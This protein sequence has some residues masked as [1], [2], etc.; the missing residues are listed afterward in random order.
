MEENYKIEDESGDKNYFTIVPNYILNHSTAKAQALYLQLKR[1]GGEKGIANPGSRYL[2]NKLKI[3]YNTLKKELKYLLD[4]GWIEYR[5]DVEIKTDGGLQKVKSYA[6]VDLWHMNNDYYR[7]AV[8]KEGAIKPETARTIKPVAGGYQN[9]NEIRTIER[10]KNIEETSSSESDSWILEEKLQDMEKK[11][12]SH[13]D[14]ISTFI[15]EKPVKVENSKQLSI[16]IGRFCKT[17]QKI[18]GAYTN[19][20]VFD[21][22][23]RIKSDNEARLRRNNDE[24][25]W[26]L[27]TVLKYLTK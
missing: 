24:V 7:R 18:S 5:G 2:M 25:D 3:N 13:L 11:E 22:I 10:T 23:K 12:N 1:L 19:E 27:E 15:R 4:R 21:A 6:I 26:T 17:A 16:V 9:R 14:I 20:Q 8:K